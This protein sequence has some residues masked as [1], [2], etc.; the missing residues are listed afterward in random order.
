M[1]SSRLAY[2]CQKVS[3]P[4]KMSNL[5][6][7]PAAE[8]N[9]HPVLELLRQVLPQDRPLNGLEIAS[10]TGQHVSY[11]A[12]NLPNTTWQPS[13]CELNLLENID[14]Y[15]A[16][17]KRPEAIKKAVLIDSSQPVDKW[18]SEAAKKDFF[19]FVYSCNMM[20]VSP[21]EC[22]I[23]L[24]RNSSYVLKNNGLLIIYGPMGEDGSITPQSNVD[25]DQELRNRNPSWGIRDTKDLK[26][27]GDQYNLSYVS[28]TPMPA[29]NKVII[30]Q[31]K[32]E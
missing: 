1:V 8:R 21:F 19:D 15:A 20:Q 13:E 3:S 23:G 24:F 12:E 26:K 31:K 5:M 14:R 28:T 16:L 25:F 30:F 6:K 18:P 11:F 29:N 4:N 27:L 22:T 32:S 17:S 10:G 7:Y 2:I 9:K